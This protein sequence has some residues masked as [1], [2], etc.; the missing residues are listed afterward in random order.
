MKL[1][2]SKHMEFLELFL[3]TEVIHEDGL[4]HLFFLCIAI[5][6][7]SLFEWKAPI[8][9]SEDII[10]EA[11]LQMQVRSKPGEFPSM[12]QTHFQNK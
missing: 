11:R 2:S 6:L 1:P 5:C 12:T 9:L 4:L 7:R 8:A 10:F 3:A